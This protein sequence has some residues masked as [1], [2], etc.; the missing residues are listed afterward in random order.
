MS[1][2]VSKNGWGGRSRTLTYG[3]RNRCP[4]IRRHPIDKSMSRSSKPE[5]QA[6]ESMLRKSSQFV[7]HKRHNFPRSHFLRDLRGLLALGRARS[8][9]T[10]GRIDLVL[11]F[12][13]CRAGVPLACID[14]ERLFVPWRHVLDLRR[15]Y[16][17]AC[18][19]RT[20]GALH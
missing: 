12:E 18:R 2:A 3:T 11:D 14:L 17:D 6:R 10:L 20:A 7:K 16:D 4:A 5:T 8:L 19:P 15:L 13:E 9:G 1:G